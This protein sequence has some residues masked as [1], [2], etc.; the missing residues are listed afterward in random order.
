M[1]PRARKIDAAAM[2]ESFFAEMKRYVRFDADDEAMLRAL[3]PHAAP[4]FRR[5]AEEFYARLEQH[6]QAR[7]HQV[8]H[9]EHKVVVAQ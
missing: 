2:P 6:P 7:K 9:D 5:I 4:E 3:A 8:S 1:R